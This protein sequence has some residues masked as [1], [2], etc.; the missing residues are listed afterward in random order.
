M[1]TVNPPKVGERLRNS[2]SIKALTGHPGG[3]KWRATFIEGG[4]RKQK[5]F[6]TKVAAEEWQ[7]DREEEAQ[8][9]GTSHRLTV[10]ER[11]AV[12]DTREKLAALGLD[13]RTALDHAIDYFERSQ[14][15]ATVAEVVEQ[16]IN[17]ARSSDSSDQHI[18]D[19]NTKLGKFSKKFGKRSVATISPDEIRDWLDRLKLK[20]NSINSYRNKLVTAFTHA[21][22]RGYLTENTASKVKPKKVKEAKYSAISPEEASDLIEQTDERT[23]PVIAIGLFTG[24]RTSEIKQLD[25]SAVDFTGDD[26]S[27]YGYLRIDAEIAKSSRNRLIPISKNLAHLLTPL[28]KES[29]K[30]WPVNGRKLLLAVWRAARFG[31]PGSETEDEKKEGIELKPWPRNAMRH[32]YASYHLAHHKN[33]DALALNMGHTNTS[34]IFKHYRKMVKPDAASKYWVLGLP[35]EEGKVVSIAAGE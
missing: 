3:Y 7:E 34:I 9:N 33:A 18:S 14:K 27:K 4:K 12:I 31:E 22:E 25:W 29:G 28:A 30:I 15:S 35:E 23:L 32:S 5:Y 11:S 1:Q 17:D 16:T 2:V 20:P 19:L 26:E 24:A 21:V 8:E 6:K 10:A 13:V